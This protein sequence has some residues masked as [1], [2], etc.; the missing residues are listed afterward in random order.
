MPP[1]ATDFYAA[2]LKSTGTGDAPAPE[3]WSVRDAAGRT[4]SLADAL[5]RWTGEADDVDRG[6]LTRSRGTVLDVGCGPGR[7]TAELARRGVHALGLDISP[8]ALRLARRSGATVIRRSV[9]EPVVAEGLWG[10]T[11]LADGNI[12]IGG[13][14]AALLRRCRALVAPGGLVLVETERPGVGQRTTRLRLERA[15]AVSAWF[16][17][18]HVGCDAIQQLAGGAGLRLTESWEDGGRWFAAL[19]RDPTPGIS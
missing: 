19:R 9:F 13:D 11:L 16:D 14:P 17:W 12:G 1:A 10:T 6:F 5:D 8:T 15:G 4:Y 2:A 18:A 3:P 7:L